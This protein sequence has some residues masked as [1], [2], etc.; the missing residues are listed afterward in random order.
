MG[1]GLAAAHLWG[2]FLLRIILILLQFGSG[3][4]FQHNYPSHTLTT[5]IIRV[6]HSSQV[7]DFEKIMLFTS[8]KSLFNLIVYLGFQ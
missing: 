2:R 1:S 8:A 4:A 7:S 6:S 5:L 3:L